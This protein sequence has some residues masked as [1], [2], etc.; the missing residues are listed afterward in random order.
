LISLDE[1]FRAT[2]QG[3]FTEPLHFYTEYLDPALL[4]PA[5]PVPEL[6]AL[7]VHKYGLVKLD[8]VVAVTSRALR[9]ATHHR[10]ELF[11]GVPI[12]F[13]S[14][15]RAAAA[16]LRLDDDVTGVW[17]NVDWA[18]TLE[19]A[20]RLQPETH[21]AV[22]VTGTSVTDRVWLASA[23]EQLGP[24]QGRLEIQYLTDRS[25]NEVLKQV[26]RFTKGTVLL[27]G[28]FSRDAS[29]RDLVGAEVLR[30]VSARSAVPIYGPSATYVG[31]GAVGGRV[32]SFEAQGRS[33]AGLARRVLLGERPPPTDADSNVYMFDWRQLQLWGLDESRLP[34]GSVVRFHERSAWR[35]YWGYLAAGAGLV[36][37][38]SGLIAGLLV[39]RAR[40]RRAQ[41]ALDGRLRFESLLAE[42]SATFVALPAREVDLR[43]DQ[44]LQRILEELDLDRASLAEASGPAAP[45]SIR[46]AASHEGIVPLTGLVDADAFPWMRQRLLEGH[47]VCFSRPEDLPPEAAIDRGSI[48]ALGARSLAAMP[49]KVGGQVIGALA[50]A[51]VRGEREWPAELIQRLHLVASIFASALARQRA[52]EAARES[53]GR[54]GLMREEL[55]H[56]L[57]VATLGEL[58]SA[59]V[60]EVN[61]PLAAVLTN[62][63]AVRRLLDGGPAERS[64]VLEA[65]ADIG[66][67]AKRAS[68]IVRGVR[69]MLRKEQGE[70][71]PVDV[72]AAFED[73]ISM[74]AEDFERKH[75]VVWLSLGKAL[76]PVLGD[77]VQLRQVALNLLVNACEALAGVEGASREVFIESG[78]HGPGLLE[79]CVRDTG[80][81]VK[82]SELGRIFERFVTTK[83]EGLGMGLPISRS[84][85]EAH[86]GQMWASNNADRGLT[87]HIELPCAE[88]GP[89]A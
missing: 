66:E 74:L 77:P 83:P 28:A 67:D 46:H 25:E 10:A 14:V 8:L 89:G 60:H 23:R 62:A 21:R 86:G 39:Q 26:A 59:L 31:E 47:E 61:Q 50:F 45:L 12:V 40:L 24:Y 34:A 38:Q 58:A 63:Q 54:F 19:T 3:G 32:V 49:L 20:L 37:I 30:R 82:E 15:D 51:K 84:I 85:V 71:G 6:R 1:A 70:R 13:I 65:L 79:V 42:L 17:L 78:R 35:Q 7:L 73:V 64:H 76:P 5:G 55:A 52:D 57:R 81:G 69:V 53:D 29:G 2:L 88:R 72:N 75:I 43:I 33:A 36:L 87:I 22:V 4:T 16:D 80:V 48:M 44:A 41:L 27:F 9:F 11:P 56:A 68:Q 18:A